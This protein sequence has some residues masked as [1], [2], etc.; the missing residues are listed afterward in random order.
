M[1]SQFATTPPHAP[2]WDWDSREASASQEGVDQHENFTVF[3]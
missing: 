2:M 1:N 3:T